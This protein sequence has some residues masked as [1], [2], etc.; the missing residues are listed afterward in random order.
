MYKLI[1]S[2]LIYLSILIDVS[3][4]FAVQEFH[5][6]DGDTLTIKISSRELTRIAVINGRL[7]TMWGANDSLDVQPDTDKGEIF[8]HPKLN[9]APAFSF[10]IR[11]DTGST[12]TIIAQQYDIPSETVLIKPKRRKISE[13][14]GDLSL[15]HV[16]GIK[17]LIKAMAN[18]DGLDDFDQTLV[19]KTVPL[20]QETQIKLISTY[21]STHLLGEVYRIQNISNAEMVLQEQEFS[22][23][24][25]EVQA[26]ALQHQKLAVGET[27]LLY[28]VRLANGDDL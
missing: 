6:K 26:I 7:D 3:P 12:Y 28:I 24:G 18:G 4:V 23:F 10:F 20:W 25:D 21:S 8:I 15:P 9:A 14:A 2:C 16:A 27:T 19:D 22:G 17:R 13:Q 11:D 5:A 1:I